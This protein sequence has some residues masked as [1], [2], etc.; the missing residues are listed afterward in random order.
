MAQRTYRWLFWVLAAG[1]TVLDQVSKY[2][3]FHWLPQAGAPRPGRGGG[4]CFE[5]PA[6]H[7]I[8]WLETNFTGQAD[9]GSGWFAPLRAWGVQTQPY[10]NVGALFGQRP[11]TWLDWLFRTN[12]AVTHPWLDTWVLAV[13][14]VLAA[15]GIVYWVS[16][17]DAARSWLLCGSLGLILA[18]TLGNLYDRVVFDGVRDFLHFEI[19]GVID[20]PIFNLADSFLVCGAALLVLQAFGTRAPAPQADGATRPAEMAGAQK[21]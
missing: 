19:Q 17:R 9:P 12:L 3:V 5:W 6:Q 15:A 11:T 8:F 21:G 18:G 10:L 20:W 1:G 2:A 13:V 16:R 7:G 14:S 4:G